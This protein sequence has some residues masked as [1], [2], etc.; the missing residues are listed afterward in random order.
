[1]RQMDS[2]RS[3]TKKRS[4]G[5]NIGSSSLVLI[6]VILCL[7]SF[8]ALSIASANADYK[9][10]TNVLKHS[11]SYYAACNEAE[12]DLAALDM[13]LADI[14]NKTDSKDSYFEEVG[15]TSLIMQYSL[16]ELQ[17]LQVEVRVLYPEAS[18]ERFYEVRKWVVVTSD[19]I[20]YDDSLPVLQ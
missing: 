15:V 6:F 7:I 14:Y 16:G 19:N 5:M 2:F 12:T 13:K 4:Y 1:M 9:L 10:S 8:A 3:T 17:A 11:E 18:G 20:E